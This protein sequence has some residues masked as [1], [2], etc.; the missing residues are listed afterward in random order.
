VLYEEAFVTLIKN[1]F[2]LMAIESLNLPKKKLKKIAINFYSDDELK[3]F[4]NI[5]RRNVLRLLEDANHFLAKA[6]I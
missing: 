2:R 3:S 4:K 6:R 1:H 5:S